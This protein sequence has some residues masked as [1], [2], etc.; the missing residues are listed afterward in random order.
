M[1]TFEITALD[2]RIAN[3]D[4]AIRHAVTV[5]ATPLPILGKALGKSQGA[6]PVGALV[7]II[8]AQWAFKVAYEAAATPLTYA[9]VAWLKSREALDTFDY[10]TDFNPLHLRGS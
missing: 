5:A 1:M 10:H 8:G 7:G 2:C 4:G 9:T 3:E 6:V